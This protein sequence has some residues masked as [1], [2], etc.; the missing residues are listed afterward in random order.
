VP[1][2]GTYRGDSKGD[3]WA[4]LL[5]M[6]IDSHRGGSSRRPRDYQCIL[7]CLER[8]NTYVRSDTSAQECDFTRSIALELAEQDCRTNMRAAGGQK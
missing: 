6:Q 5:Q 7:A 8:F 3:D 1:I 2:E 4:I